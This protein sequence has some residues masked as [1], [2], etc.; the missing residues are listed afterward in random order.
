MI[1]GQMSTELVRGCLRLGSPQSRAWDAGLCGR[2][3]VRSDL[4]EGK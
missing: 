1:D 4:R 3:Y 2:I